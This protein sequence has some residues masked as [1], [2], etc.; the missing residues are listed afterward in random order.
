MLIFFLANGSSVLYLLKLFLIIMINLNLA[1]DNSL[2]Q[3]KLKIL[4]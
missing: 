4:D 1:I 2:L 3:N